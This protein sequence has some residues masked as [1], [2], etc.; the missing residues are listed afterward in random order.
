MRLDR[1]VRHHAEAAGPLAGEALGHRKDFGIRVAQDHLRT[2]SRQ[3][4]GDRRAQALGG[5]GHDGHAPL[6]C[7]RRRGGN[8]HAA[9]VQR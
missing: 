3:G 4:P 1:H 2:R 9:C 8:G 6:Q 7:A 5:A